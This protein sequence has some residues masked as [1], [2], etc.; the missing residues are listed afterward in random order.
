MYVC[1]Y[2]RF[3]NRNNLPWTIT[4]NL[5]QKALQIFTKQVKG[6][7]LHSMT[8]ICQK[9]WLTKQFEN[10]DVITCTQ[11]LMLLKHILQMSV[12]AFFVCNS[13]YWLSKDDCIF[14]EGFLNFKNPIVN[15]TKTNKKVPSSYSHLNCD[16]YA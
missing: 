4:T 2:I 6:L 7:Q 11:I 16:L 8:T 3:K 10:N 15:I 1:T 12:I 14:E 5:R 9:Q 13:F